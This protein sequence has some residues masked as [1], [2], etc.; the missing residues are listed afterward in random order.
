MSEILEKQKNG[1]KSSAETFY[2]DLVKREGQF[3]K[4]LSTSVIF[5]MEKYN[6]IYSY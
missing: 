5:L 4:K 2:I 3:W 1:S 6:M